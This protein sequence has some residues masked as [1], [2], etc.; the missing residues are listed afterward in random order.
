M[1]IHKNRCRF[2]KLEIYS[3]DSNIDYHEECL[4]QISKLNT[5]E[6][7]KLLFNL[8][9]KKSSDANFADGFI[10]KQAVIEENKIT[11][12]FI[13]GQYVKGKS[14]KKIAIRKQNSDELQEIFAQLESY[15]Y[16]FKDLHELKITKI[17]IDVLPNSIL[18]LRNLNKISL[19][20]SS[21]SS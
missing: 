8:G 21:L 2:C 16:L 6:L 19:S 3:N 10:T 20:N 14:V 5:D 11:K 7:K 12:L 1:N 15:F 13:Q 18:N 17:D 9:F 4:E